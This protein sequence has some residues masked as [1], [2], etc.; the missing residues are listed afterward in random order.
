MLK[1]IPFVRSDRNGFTL[2]ELIVGI[3]LIALI[4]ALLVAVLRGGV[5]RLTRI[6]TDKLVKQEC[7]QVTRP[8]GSGSF[9]LTVGQIADFGIADL[10]GPSLTVRKVK[11]KWE[12]R[13]EGCFYTIVITGETGDGE[14]GTVESEESEVAC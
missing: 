6:T 7:A 11:V 10:A 14:E 4:T 13:R 5:G 1:S 12:K 3:C 9:D 2:I 8:V